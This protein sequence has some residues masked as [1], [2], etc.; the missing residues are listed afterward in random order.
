MTHNQSFT[1]LEW[2][3]GHQFHNSPR[4]P[5]SAIGRRLVERGG[6]MLATR[7][8]T[9]LF[10]EET[11]HDQ[12]QRHPARGRASAAQRAGAIYQGPVV[13]ESERAG[14]AGAADPAAADQQPRS[15]ERR[16]GK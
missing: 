6:A 5:T 12:W 15:E 7:P 16:V 2:V 11:F 14:L 9:G 13:R 8:D 4:H 10:G 3:G 1:T